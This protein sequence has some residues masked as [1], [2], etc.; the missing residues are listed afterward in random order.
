MTDTPTRS[1]L[2]P[3]RPLVSAR[4]FGLLT[5]HEFGSI[6]QVR[7][8][9]SDGLQPG[10]YKGLGSVALLEIKLAL[11][12]LPPA[13]ASATRGAP[14]KPAAAAEQPIQ[15]SSRAQAVV[16]PSVLTER[17]LT[18][19]IE[20]AETGMEQLGPQWTVNEAE[21]AIANLR[22]QRLIS[23]TLGGPAPV[24]PLPAAPVNPPALSPQPH[25]GDAP[26]RAP[27]NWPPRGAGRPEPEPMD[28]EELTF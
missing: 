28:D 11:A 17:E 4:T 21:T 12:D 14:E 10:D 16:F 9:L 3:L 6:A 18:L 22:Q 8:E 1:P 24:N 5:R 23:S 15:S 20:L 7:Q 27:E 13:A 25:P 2:A 26:P 19:L